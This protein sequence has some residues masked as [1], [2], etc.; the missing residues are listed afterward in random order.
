VPVASGRLPLSHLAGLL[1]LLFAFAGG[2]EAHLVDAW[3]GNNIDCCRR[4]LG[5]ELVTVQTRS[6]IPE[7]SANSPT[8]TS[9]CYS[10]L[11]PLLAQVFPTRPG[12]RGMISN[13]TISYKLYSSI[14]LKSPNN[15]GIADAR[16]V[17]NIRCPNCMH[18]G[19]FT[20][21]VSHDLHI[22]HSELK[23]GALHRLGQS[24]VGLRVCQI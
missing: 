18:M 14:N 10:S 19:A 1:L 16:Q 9:A 2:A 8:A 13:M 15:Q 20:A 23:A 11:S 12:R 22:T 3:R 21:V 7:V 17:P 5:M 6:V 4:R 24:T